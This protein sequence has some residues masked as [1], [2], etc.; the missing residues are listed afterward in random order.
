MEFKHWTSTIL[1]FGSYAKGED[2]ES[3]DIDLFLI[4]REKQLNLKKFEEE[5]GMTFE[6]HI[7]TSFEKI[8]AALKNNLINGIVIQGFLKGY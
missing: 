7:R 8:P 2:T 4:G 6:L 5:L 3:S 1:L